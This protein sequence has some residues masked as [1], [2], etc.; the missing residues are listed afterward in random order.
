MFI[1]KRLLLIL[2]L[3]F[4]FQSLTKADDIRDFQIEGMS[5]GDSLVDYLDKEKINKKIIK[6]DYKSDKFKAIFLTSSHRLVNFYDALYIDFKKNDKKFIIH[7]FAGIKSYENIPIKKCLNKKK[8]VVDELKILFSNIIMQDDIH[9]HPQDK[10][11]KSK[12]Y[13]TSFG[14]QKNSDWLPIEVSCYDWS[15]KMSYDDH[16]R[17]N[18]KSDE[19]ND[20][21]RDEAYK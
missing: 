11:G 2:I 14:I 12:V 19:Y 15:K 4:N 9:S 17:I 7:S 6:Q 1:M 13:R 8:E 3:T 18:I 20:W 10:T 5:I 16:L 21:L